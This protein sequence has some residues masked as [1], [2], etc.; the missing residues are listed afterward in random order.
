MKHAERHNRNPDADEWSIRQIG[1]YLHANDKDDSSTVILLNPSKRFQQ[2]HLRARR[3]G[4]SSLAD[5]ETLL[6]SAC[7]GNWDEF[8]DYLEIR[9]RKRVNYLCSMI[10]MKIANRDSLHRHLHR[11]CSPK[12]PGLLLS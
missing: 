4:K 2:R 10:L 12:V 11:G 6:Y 8:L 1:V 5:V 9:L 7:L 3:N